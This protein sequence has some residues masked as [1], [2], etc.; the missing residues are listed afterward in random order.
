M[1]TATESKWISEPFRLGTPGA[2]RARSG[3]C[4]CGPDSRRRHCARAPA[5]NSIYEFPR[6]ESRSAFKDITDAQSLFVRLFIDGE[7]VA[8]GVVE[9]NLSAGRSRRCSSRSD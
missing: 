3:S 8:R 7:Q 5:S 6:P 2:V 9:S 4:S 1:T